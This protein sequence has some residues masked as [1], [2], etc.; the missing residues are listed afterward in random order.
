MHIWP[1]FA[2]LRPI[3]SSSST[4]LDVDVQHSILLSLSLS[5]FLTSIPIRYLLIFPSVFAKWDFFPLFIFTV[6]S[7]IYMDVCETHS[8][9]FVAK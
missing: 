3:I 2:R 9:V 8:D 4:S 7:F 1:G 5:F 6:D